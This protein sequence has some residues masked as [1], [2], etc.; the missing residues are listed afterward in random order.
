V[1]LP[2]GQ[3]LI[4]EYDSRMIRPES[5]MTRKNRTNIHLIYF[6]KCSRRT[7]CT[8]KLFFADRR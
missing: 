4:L 6:L 3:A 8:S 2:I 7:C 5:G 1:K